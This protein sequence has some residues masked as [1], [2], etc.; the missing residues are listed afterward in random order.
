M[1]I[2]EKACKWTFSAANCY[3]ADLNHIWPGGMGQES[4]WVVVVVIIL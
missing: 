3:K 4:A 1:L 2:R